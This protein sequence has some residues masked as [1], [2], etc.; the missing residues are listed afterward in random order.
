MAQ[1]SWY[2]VGAG[3]VTGGVVKIETAHT[4]DYSGTWAEIDSVDF[5]SPALTNAAYWATGP[6]HMLF[7]RARVSS[8][9][10]GGGTI[11]VFFCG[12]SGTQGG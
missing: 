1:A 6:G 8:N 2:V 3:T 12:L 11:S 10:T 9:V 5:S 4:I 7:M